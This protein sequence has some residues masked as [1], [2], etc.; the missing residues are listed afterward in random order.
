M[1]KSTNEAENTFGRNFTRCRTSVSKNHKSAITDQ[2][3]GGNRAHQPSVW[4]SLGSILLSIFYIPYGTK[5]TT[6][7]FHL[8]LFSVAICCAT[9][10]VSSTLPH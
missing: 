5:V 8:T 4:E 2:L 1:T 10:H 7:F 3:N 9:P 6:I